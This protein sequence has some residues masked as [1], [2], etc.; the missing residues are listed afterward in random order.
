[1]IL[2]DIK[3]VDLITL[4]L[5]P[6]MT[7]A[8]D[9]VILIYP[10]FICFLTSSN[11]PLR[12]GCLNLCCL[13]LPKHMFFMLSCLFFHS[14]SYCKM[15]MTLTFMLKVNQK[16][17]CVPLSTFHVATPH[18]INKLFKIILEQ[19]HFIKLVIFE[20]IMNMNVVISVPH[21]CSSYIGQSSRCKPVKTQSPGRY[22]KNGKKERKET[23]Y[24][25]HAVL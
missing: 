2:G 25:K 15:R 1:M 11:C 17:F 21:S 24:L 4:T 20:V 9:L 14:F 3:I 8:N 12:D 18:I 16:Y 13:L 6:L 10:L 19:V 22:C 5:S 23:H 7:S